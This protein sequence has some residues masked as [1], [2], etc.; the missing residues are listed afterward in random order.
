M[1]SNFS[2]Y[3]DLAGSLSK[4]APALVHMGS[5]HRTIRARTARPTHSGLEP[6]STQRKISGE[7]LESAEARYGSSRMRV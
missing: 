3:V 5:L 1:L 4:L 6:T 7:T 2:I